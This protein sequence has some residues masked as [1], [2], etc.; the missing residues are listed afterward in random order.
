MSVVDF[1]E[2]IPSN[3]FAKCTYISFY[4]LRWQ[5]GSSDESGSE[6]SDESEDSVENGDFNI[7]VGVFCT[8]GFQADAQLRG[9]IS[10]LH[11]TSRH[12]NRSLKAH[13]RLICLEMTRIPPT[14]QIIIV[15]PSFKLTIVFVRELSESIQV[16]TTLLI[17]NL[18]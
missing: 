2:L 15:L 5:G 8:M 10:F 11:C 17:I 14:N 13:R 6:I 9:L 3:D 1:S 7:E 4:F 12:L 18:L 16:D